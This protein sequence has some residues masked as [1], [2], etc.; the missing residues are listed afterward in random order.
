VKKPTTPPP[1]PPPPPPP[2]P[3]K[4]PRRPSTS[5]PVIRRN[6][7]ENAGRPKREIHPPPPKDLPY[8]DAP[9]KKR[10]RSVKKDASNEQLRYCAKILDQLGRKQHAAVV[11]PFAEPVGEYLLILSLPASLDV[12]LDWA[13]L[14]I[15][16][17]PKIVKKPMDL[18][19]L[20][21]KLDSGA[22]P[23]AEKFRD[24]FKLLVSNCFL[25][26]PPSTPVHQ[27]GVEL[28]KL[29]EEKW[30]GLPPL[31][32]E[33]EDEE[34][35][36]DTDSEEERARAR[37]SFIMLMVHSCD[38]LCS[39]HCCHG[40]PNRDHAEQYQCPEESE[41]EEDDKEIKEKGSVYLNCCDDQSIEKRYKSGP[42]EESRIEEVPDSR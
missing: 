21:N 3:K 36:D 30:K 23:T 5:V 2:V 13:K 24:D 28:K 1:P 17:Y 4:A 34:D 38:W 9:K 14:A 19:T 10:R 37:M 12:F 41:G 31:R 7:T 22:Y 11:G 25:Y 20:R 35:E 29:F 39:H 16:D 18:S 27:A 26:N 40:V 32:A 15:P 8:A 6:E 42:E 33:S